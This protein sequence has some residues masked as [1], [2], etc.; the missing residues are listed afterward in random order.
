MLDKTRQTKQQNRK[1]GQYT[2]T[3]VNNT[4]VKLFKT[5]ENTHK[6]KTLQNYLTEIKTQTEIQGG[7]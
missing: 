7:I 6:E 2:R 5:T 1:P 3:Q 4:Q